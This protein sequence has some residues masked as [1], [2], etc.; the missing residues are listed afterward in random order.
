MTE[1][2]HTWEKDTT[3]EHGRPPRFFAKCTRCHAKTQAV[4]I[5]GHVHPFDTSHRVPD[6][7]KKKMRSIRLSDVEMDSIAKGRLSLTV[8]GKRITIAV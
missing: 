7:H 1:H 2:E 8:V 5:S 3:R 6:E 4:M